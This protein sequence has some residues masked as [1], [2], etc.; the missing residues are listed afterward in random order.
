M[1]AEPALA[2]SKPV[3]APV[4]S[5]FICVFTFW[6]LSRRGTGSEAPSPSSGASN[7]TLFATYDRTIALVWLRPPAALGALRS[8]RTL[9]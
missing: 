1:Q 7:V 8:L 5:A 4:P 2:P 3:A 9:R 6:C